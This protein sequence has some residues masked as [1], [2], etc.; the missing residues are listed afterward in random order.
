MS[1]RFDND[2]LLAIY[3]SESLGRFIFSIRQMEDSDSTWWEA[4]LSCGNEAVKATVAG[5]DYIPFPVSRERATRTEALDLANVVFEVDPDAVLTALHDGV[6]RTST[7]F[8]VVIDDHA[9]PM[10]PA[11]L[12]NGDIGRYGITHL[13]V[14]DD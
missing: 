14:W 9:L 10:G 11:K 6:T 5:N 8:G 3:E 4:S 13:E 2:N 1:Y 12:Y 7:H